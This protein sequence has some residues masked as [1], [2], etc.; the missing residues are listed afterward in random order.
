[1]TNNNGSGSGNGNGNSNDDKNS[2]TT[3]TGSATPTE[4]DVY[5]R[6]IRLWGA[7]SQ[8]KMQSSKILYL[9]VT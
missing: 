5:D 2:I 4:S 6:Q 9:L 3:G 8:A 7:E 1:M